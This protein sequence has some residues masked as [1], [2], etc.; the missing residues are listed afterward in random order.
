MHLDINYRN[1]DIK[2]PAPNFFLFPFLRLPK[3]LRHADSKDLVE[4]GK[5]YCH[6][7][8]YLTKILESVSLGKM[9][10]NPNMNIQK[11]SR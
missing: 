1:R 11:L 2:M 3:L 6:V 9:M 4:L 8:L 7:K 5:E 10:Q